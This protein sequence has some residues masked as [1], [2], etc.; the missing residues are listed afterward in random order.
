ML[1]VYDIA[2]MI[3]VAERDAGLAEGKQ[4]LV[5]DEDAL[6]AA[7]ESGDHRV[8]AGEARLGQD[9]PTLVADRREVVLSEVPLRGWGTFGPPAGESQKTR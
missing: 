5:R 7:R 1:P 2:T 9:Y 8:R 3:L 6:S 4:P